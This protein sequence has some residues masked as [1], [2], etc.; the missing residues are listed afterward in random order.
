MQA[1][2]ALEAMQQPVTLT[3]RLNVNGKQAA[4]KKINMHL[5]SKHQA[6]NACLH[7]SDSPETDTGDQLLD[8]FAQC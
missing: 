4:G 7:A 1:K 2:P 6:R 3:T 5:V 8:Y